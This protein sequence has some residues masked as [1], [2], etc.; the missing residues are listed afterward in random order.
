MAIFDKKTGVYTYEL[1]ND[2]LRNFTGTA[3]VAGTSDKYIYLSS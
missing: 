2:S 3:I 1:T